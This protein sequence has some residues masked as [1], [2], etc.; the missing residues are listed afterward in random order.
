M[1]AEVALR[2]QHAARGE[3][4]PDT[5]FTM[6]GLASA[7]GG[8]GQHAEAAEMHRT[9]LEARRRV[10]GEEHPHTLDSMNS[11]ASGMYRIGDEL[12]LSLDV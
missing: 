2:E 1:M 6:R 12:W 7:L 11:L 10:L 4:H 5:L 3:K 9:T 8:A